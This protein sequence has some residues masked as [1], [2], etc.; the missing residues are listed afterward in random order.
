MLSARCWSRVGG[1]VSYTTSSFNPVENEAVVL[2]ALRRAG[3][4][5]ELAPPP[6]GQ[7]D[8]LGLERAPGLT[9]WLVPDPGGL[10]LF[11]M[12]ERW[13]DVAAHH[14]APKG[15][16]MRTMFPQ[17]YGG[18]VHEVEEVESDVLLD[19]MRVLPHKIIGSGRFVALL[20]KLAP[21]PPSHARI[22]PA[23][24]GDEGA[25]HGGA[26]A[27]EAANVRARKWALRI[28]PLVR[29]GGRGHGGPD[30]ATPTESTRRD[31]SAAARCH[32]RAAARARASARSSMA[33]LRRMT[34]RCV[35]RASSS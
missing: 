26:M 20:R 14:R 2:A 11:R 33:V 7:N 35:R 28:R 16:L 18:G 6:S 10:S 17:S 30:S 9:S 24:D 23:G 31:S 12:Y 25:G 3:G 34:C 21:M 32:A 29:E 5:C 4:A 15:P 8:L 13:E 19:C 27:A 1:L 22:E